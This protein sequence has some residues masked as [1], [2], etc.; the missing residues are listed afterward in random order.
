MTGVD[1]DQGLPEAVSAPPAQSGP[2]EPPPAPPPARPLWTY[3]LTPA[4]VV[5][6]SLVIAGAVW[7]TNRESNPVTP[8]SVVAASTQPATTASPAAGNGSAPVASGQ[9]DLLSVFD[10]YAKQV[11]LDQAKFTQCL[12]NPATVAVIN[13]QLQR[14]NALGINGTPTFFINNKMI[15]GAQPTEIFDEVIQ[16]EI[17]GSPATIDGYSA[18]IKQLAA[19]NP[20]NFKIL[21]TKPD[22]SD[23]QFEGSPTA[24][25]IVAEFSDF[26]CPFCKRFVDT[27]LA[28]IRAEVGAQVAIAFLNFPLTQIHPNAGNA[29]LVAACAG[30]Q[31]KFWPMHD[32]LFARQG[33][34]ESLRAK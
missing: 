19:T 20:P 17:K 28:H 3:F 5:L 4:A 8:A 24:K 9:P 23:A 25:V 29:S 26:Q 12:A 27:T 14:G 21:A 33:E 15:V 30:E 6:G 22:V 7:Y 13:R 1:D 16:D 10:G 18:A 2:P 32:L 31:G 11:G 34:W